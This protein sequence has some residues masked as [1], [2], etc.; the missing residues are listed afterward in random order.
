ME[1]EHHLRAHHQYRVSP[2]T[3]TS[4]DINVSSDSNM[5]GWAGSDAFI[6]DYPP[7]F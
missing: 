4:I 1:L 3:F 5:R 2:K 6:R 7:L